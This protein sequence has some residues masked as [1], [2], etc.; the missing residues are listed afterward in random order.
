MNESRS[1]SQAARSVGEASLHPS[2][3]AISFST[4]LKGRHDMGPVHR[5][6]HLACGEYLLKNPEIQESTPE[7]AVIRTLISWLIGHSIL[8]LGWVNPVRA[9]G[10]SEV[11]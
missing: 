4:T 5:L 6:I 1:S 8:P 10:V 2:I 7:G 3:K 9:L 11:R